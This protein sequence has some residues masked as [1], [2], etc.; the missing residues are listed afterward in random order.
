MTD[1]RH[2]FQTYALSDRYTRQDGRV[3]L[4]GTQALVRILLDQARRDRAAGL[5]TGGFVSGYR[6]SPLGAFD[7]ELWGAQ[8]LIAQ[9]DI[10]FMPAVNEDLGATAVL[11]AQQASLDPACVHEG[12][13]GMWYGKGPGVDRSGDALRHGNAYGSS[14][15]GGV[16]VVAGD[17]HGCV[18][19]SMPHQSDVAFMTWFMPTL[20]PANVAEYLEF[21]A[22]GYAL[23]R[24]SGT[25]VGFKAI[26]ETVESGQSLIL[27][28]E[29]RFTLPEI[30]LPP[31]GLHVRRGDLPSPEIEARIGH[32]LRAVE[33]F[34]EANP[35]DRRIYDLPDARFGIV[36]TGK[37][38]LDTMEALRLLGLQEA[39]CHRLGIDIYKVGMVWP[40]ARR[41]A[42]DFVRGKKEVLVIEEKRGIIE[43]QFKEYFY[44]WPG[45]KPEK[46]VGKHDAA[47]TRDLVP[48]TGELSPLQLV[49]ILAER[50][51]RHFPDEGL[52][53]KARA[54]RAQPPILLSVEGAKRTPYFCSGCPHNTSTRLPEGSKAASGIGCHVMASWMNRETDGFA[55]MGGEGVPVAVA[56]KYNG[57]KHMFQN[58]GEG[59]WYHSGSLAL[60]QAVAAGANITFKIL[61]NDAVAM[62][63]GQ[64]VDGPISVQNIAL[65]SRAEGVE[66]IAVVS[67]NPAK[68]HLRDFPAGTS[69]HGRADL[70]AVQRELREIPGVTVLI[71]EQSCATEKRRRRKRGQEDD[72]KRFVMINPLVCEGCGDC[73]VESNCLS[74]EPL[75]TPLGRKRK[76]N[77]SSCNKDFSCLNGFCPSF[78][79]LEGATRRKKTGAD[80]D[81]APLLADLPAPRLPDLAQP[82]DL[83]VTGV[84]GTGVVTVGAV[85][86]MAAHLEG[87]GA[88]VLDFTGFAQKFGTVLSYIRL[89]QR[90]ED[91]HQVRIDQGA[92]EAVI[93]C[94]AVVSSSPAAS[95]HYRPGTQIVLNRAEMPTGD[96]VLNRDAQLR[97]DARADVIAGAVG[98]EN[99]FG[100]DANRL[101][102]RLMGDAVFANV[103]ML[104]YAWQKGLVP[105]SEM[106]LKQ[107]I[108][109]NGTAVERNH[110]AFDLGR[111]MA[112]NPDALPQEEPEKQ[113]ET[114]A[115]VIAHRAE[116]LTGYQNAGYAQR[117]RDRLEAFRAALPPAHAEEL[118]L[119]AAKALFR[120]MACKDEYE[121]ARL[122][123][124]TSFEEQILAEFEPGFRVNF[125]MAPPL[126]NWGKDAR[127]RPLKRSFGPWLAPLLRW[128][129]RGRGL[130]GTWADPFRF[131][132][133]RR[134]EVA[135]I[136]WYEGVMRDVAAHAQRGNLA[137]I[138]RI[139]SSALEFRGYGPVKSAA[140]AKGKP[141]ADRL[142]ASL[143]T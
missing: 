76:I 130:R 90:P 47:A 81:L 27:P 95:R 108:V 111:V 99:L 21:G 46:M 11:G 138:R 56:Q 1:Q 25:W 122:H 37:G 10:T 66:R 94:D 12:I 96:L 142:L 29:R 112:A 67:D 61:Y 30:E 72:P 131:S 82:Y 51:D 14:P 109:L 98:A 128:L 54:L 31:G 73:S 52:P 35:I 118:T 9:H 75:E 49:P 80:L 126:L 121:V 2:A 63:G 33:A 137:L 140:I 57:G 65:S 88:S 127:G 136:G 60:R 41:A 62:T 120:L 59:T 58:L 70:D 114:L 43:S 8:E 143:K 78:V 101:A 18:S 116:F 93:G 83:L 92:A 34:I 38:H 85:V 68:F 97:I 125:H 86:T 55:Q 4:T 3:F 74:V 113:P 104:G 77:L 141:E 133:D 23:S 26:S 124:Q 107:A 45:D 39:V 7:K 135:L 16:L 50:L 132:H 102:E 139:L 71:Y 79:T 69:L 53:A 36:T 115:E 117:Y 42:L 5:N 48:W 22:Y 110:R 64:P 24:Y 119:I 134:E 91:I 28:P 106:A 17:D 32:K 20:N 44:D 6:G 40:L 89:G 100:F 87:K 103:M 105:V 129:A 13:F 123:S 84:G 15:R 19:S